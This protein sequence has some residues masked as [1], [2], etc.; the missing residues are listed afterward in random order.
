MLTPKL[1]SL[2]L[3]TKLSFFRGTLLLFRVMNPLL[4]I[5]CVLMEPKWT[6]T[7]EGVEEEVV[8]VS[9]R[10]CSLHETCSSQNLAYSV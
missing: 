1:L 6:L 9:D 7:L 2:I 10:T 5:H 3:S 4:E 8:P